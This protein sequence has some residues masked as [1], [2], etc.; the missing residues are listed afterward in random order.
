MICL[1][2]PPGTESFRFSVLSVSLPLGLAYVAGALEASGREVQVID[3]VGEA[4]TRRTRYVRG[5]LI[6]LPLDEI[7]ARIPE[8]AAF[9]GITVIF[10]HE[11]P[12]VV[13]LVELIKARRPQVPIVLGGEHVTSMSEFCLLTSKADILVLGEGEETIVELAAA[14]EAGRPLREVDGIAFRDTDEIVVNRRRRRTR[15]VDSIPWP[16]WHLFKLRTY[17]EHRLVGGMYSSSMAMPMLATR[18]CPYQCTYC[19]APNMWTPLWIARDPVKVVDELA[20]LRR[21]LWRGHL[22]F[23]GSHRHHPEG[24]D[25]HVLPRAPAP[26]SQDHLAAADGHAFRS[27]RRRGRR[28]APAVGHDEHGVRARVGL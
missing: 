2:R 5:Y 22:S 17:H 3:A 13:R 26:R 14:L 4:P 21:T 27:H 18:G 6:G 11:W 25:R 16:A 1:V 9:V 8:S 24:L 19:S 28:A 20:A 15:D 23:P 10:T 12:A 7:A